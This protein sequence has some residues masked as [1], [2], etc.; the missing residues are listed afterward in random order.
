MKN[1]SIALPAGTY[2]IGDPCYVFN[3]DGWDSAL[4]STDYFEEFTV[5]YLDGFAYA[6][7]STM[8]GDGE[9]YDQEGNSYPVDAGLIGAVDMRIVEAQGETTEAAIKSEK[10]G[11]VI[12]FA[13]PVT[14][15]RSEDGMIVIGNI[16]IDTG[17][18]FED[19]CS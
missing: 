19:V 13:N 4:E 9:Y 12:T 11:I 8:Y 6:A 1:Q 18:D 10:F 15:G 2:Y 14:I 7:A 3:S 5:N 16:R 17:S